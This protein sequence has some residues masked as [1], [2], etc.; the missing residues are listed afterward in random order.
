M[1]K[2]FRS[3]IGIT[4]KTPIR[5][6]HSEALVATYCLSNVSLEYV[7]PR[8]GDHTESSRNGDRKLC[9]TRCE[10]SSPDYSHPFSERT[11]HNLSP[12]YQNCLC[13]YNLELTLQDGRQDTGFQNSTTEPVY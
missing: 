5:N 7:N 11:E 2:T 12:G 9:S 10:N 3:V 1:G 13:D 8:R 4:Y 6:R